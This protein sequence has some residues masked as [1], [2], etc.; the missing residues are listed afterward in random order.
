MIGYLIKRPIA[1][2]T[3]S[4]A[5]IFLGI[6]AAGRMPTSLMPDIDIPEITIRISYPN[7]SAREIE[8][9]IVRT[10]RDNLLQ[11]THLK[12]IESESKDE[13]ASIKLQFEYG[14]KIHYAFIETNE[15]IDAAQNYLP[16]DLQRPVVIK[17]SATDIPVLNLIVTPK[18]QNKNSFLQLGSFARQVIKKRIEQLPEVGIAD[19]SGAPQPEIVV[20]PKIELM[21]QTGITPDM[22]TNTLKNNNIESG[23]FI[24]QNGIYQYKFKFDNSLNTIDDIKNLN[25]LHQGKLYRIGELCQVYQQ[26]QKPLGQLVHNGNHSIIFSVIKQKGAKISALKEKLYQLIKQFETDYP[27]LNFKVLNDQSKILQISISNLFTS[28]I[29]GTFLAVLILFFFVRN[30]K[31]P[32]IIAISIPSSLLISLLLLY[33]FNISLN[34]IS[35]S[36]LVLGVGLMIDNAIIVIDNIV[37]KTEDKDIFQSVTQGTIEVVSP[38]ISSALTTVSVFVPL[39]FLSGIAGALFYDQAISVSVGLLASILVSIILIPVIFYV[40]ALKSGF[41]LKKENSTT[42]FYERTYV[43]FY[44]H[45]KIVLA[46]AIFGILLLGLLFLLPK[47]KLPALTQTD[48]VVYIDWNEPVSLTENQ[49]RLD[50]LMKLFPEIEHYIS[51]TGKQ[52]FILKKQNQQDPNQ[53]RVYVKTRSNSDLLHFK[54]TLSKI[55]PPQVKLNYQPAEN[56]FNYMF[57]YDNDAKFYKIFPKNQSQLPDLENIFKFKEKYHL[58]ALDIP[59]QPVLQIKVLQD[60]LL[61]YHISYNELANQLQAVFHQNYID[62]LKNEKEFIPI[63]LSYNTTDIFKN[64]NNLFVRNQEGKQIP[65]NQL[66][67]IRKNQQYKCLTADRKGEYISF[68]TKNMDT[69]LLKDINQNSGFYITA[70][71]SFTDNT[72]KELWYSIL[73]SLILLYL[74]MAAQF[75]S[76]WQPLIILLEIPIDIGFALLFL[77]LFGSSINI[78]SLIGIIVMS[79]IVVNDSILKIHTINLLRNKGLSVDDAIHEAGKLRLKPILMTSLTTILALLPF[80]FMNGLGAELQKP[81]ALVVIG[82]LLFGTFIS[83]FFV[84]LAYRSLIKL[85]LKS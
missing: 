47:Q 42:T 61:L 67:K 70:P 25:L 26:A 33:V 45:K 24:I 62:R 12:N 73:I 59:T 17:A 68:I 78:M 30:Y 9:N 41:Y 18:N 27:E 39:I 36:G 65:V 81:L 84:P 63:Q 43:Y 31:I 32:L 3:I 77:Y 69:K 82:G 8:N 49:K 21:Q 60:R 37:Q 6:I 52:D 46:I 1:V 76:F 71:D 40:L 44:R 10:L 16:K 5:I 75:E 55:L 57:G 38:L 11:V 14:T 80:L 22:I 15:K 23:N 51:Y 53:S 79:G 56:V 28:L 58:N 29:L 4:L 19:M 50:S 20:A 35:L 83:L 85:N 74:I 2:F 7:H 66:I 72:S 54:E 64:L 48:T 13:N 34:I